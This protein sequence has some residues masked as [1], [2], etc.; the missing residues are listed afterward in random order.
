MSLEHTTT[1]AD[2]LSPEARAWLAGTMERN[3]AR[4]GGWSMEADTGSGDGDSGDDSSDDNGSDDADSQGSSDDDKADNDDTGSEDDKSDDKRVSKAN[5]E[6]QRYRQQAR[7][8]QAAAKKAQDVLDAITKAVSGDK[9]EDAKDP[10]VLA[11]EVAKATADLAST[12]RELAVF[13][14]A[15]SAGANA[16]ALLDSRS[17]LESL[18]DIDATDADKI[19][20]AIKDAVKK[21]PAYRL[22]QGSSAGGGDIDPGKR[23]QTGSVTPEQFKRMTFKERVALKGSNPSLYRQLAG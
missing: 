1:P 22:T 16:S 8:A 13:K 11:Q 15:A 18:A 5:K 14:A 4:F 23:E 12:Q 20:A 17:F 3:A 19:T 2:L 7:D 6:S 10:A 21:N 9:G